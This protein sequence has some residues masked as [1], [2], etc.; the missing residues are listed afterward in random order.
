[1]NRTC[2]LKDLS[3]INRDLNKTLIV[4]NFHENFN[5]QKDNGIHIRGWY[6]KTDD[7]VLSTLDTI[8]QKMVRAQPYDVRDYLKHVFSSKKYDGL[9]LYS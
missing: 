6:G 5:L 9:A 4:D 8:L 2:H 7:R 1:M 3:R